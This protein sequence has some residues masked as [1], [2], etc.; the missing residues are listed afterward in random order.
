MEKMTEMQKK[1]IWTAVFVLAAIL[2]FTLVTKLATSAAFVQN[3][4][5]SL[6][7]KKADVLELMGAST[8]ASVTVSAIPGDMATPIAEKMADLSTAFL[9]ILCAVY[10]EKYVVS[11]A[12]YA[13][14]RL[15]VPAAMILFAV[16]QHKKSR[17]ILGI[18]ARLLALG[19]AVFL[20]VPVSV[21]VSDLVETSYQE[22]V[23]EALDSAEQVNGEGDD[24]TGSEDAAASEDKASGDKASEDKTDSNSS[25]SDSKTSGSTSDKSDSPGL[26]DR[27]LGFAGNAKDAASEAITGLTALPAQT[28]AELQKM[29]N[30]FM[31]AIAAMIITSCV[32]PLLILAFFVWVIKMIFGSLQT[33][34]PWPVEPPKSKKNFPHQGKRIEDKSNE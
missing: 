31:E 29:L 21:K 13:A 32:V 4:L 15:L 18:G 9:V 19:L 26:L 30:D 14:F 2:S 25:S 3:I 16:W 34:I 5:E 28:V 22:S 23:Q 33:V 24:K 8:A 7:Q 6:D 27:L 1:W 10:L 12:G 20:M 17:V 11:I